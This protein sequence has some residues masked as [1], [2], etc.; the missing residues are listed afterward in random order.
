MHSYKQISI[1]LV[2]LLQGFSSNLS[3]DQKLERSAVDGY[4]GREI[5]AQGR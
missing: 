5:G 1:L 3:D 4:F 2:V